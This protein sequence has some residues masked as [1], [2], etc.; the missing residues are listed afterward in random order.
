MK[1]EQNL[2]LW[3]FRQV[4]NQIDND[5]IDLIQERLYLMPELA[6]FKKENWLKVEHPE[7]EMELYKK[8]KELAEEK[9]VNPEIIVKIF[10]NIIEESKKIQSENIK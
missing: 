7:R 2:Q 5:I 6:K 1:Q 9:W 8:Y 3:A 4:I 10:F